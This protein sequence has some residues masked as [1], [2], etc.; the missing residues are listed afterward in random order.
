[1][2]VVEGK[3]KIIKKLK[4]NLN[5]YQVAYD[6]KIILNKLNSLID[7]TG[8][9][10]FFDTNENEDIN[11]IINSKPSIE[12][13]S[14]INLCETSRE[15][16]FNIMSDSPIEK[17]NTKKKPKLNS[18]KKSKKKKKESLQNESIEKSQSE[19]QDKY[20]SEPRQPVMS[21]RFHIKQYIIK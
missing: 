18:E 17:Y 5:K 13:I 6:E 8:L 20:A 15:D 16:Y 10:S 3:E 21:K 4:E 7:S 1:M 11:K 9:I 19:L 2:S 14:I 12:N